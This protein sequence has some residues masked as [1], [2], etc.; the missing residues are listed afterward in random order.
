MSNGFLPTITQFH[1]FHYLPPTCGM[2]TVETGFKPGRPAGF[3]AAE[4]RSL[5][6]ESLRLPYK[7]TGIAAGI[8]TA[9]TLV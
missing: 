3:L 6:T 4:I 2:A 7:S 5:A 8:A 9:L 1:L